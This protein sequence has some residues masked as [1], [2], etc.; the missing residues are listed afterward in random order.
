ML[1]LFGII[2]INYVK[3]KSDLISVS[4]ISFLKQNLIFPIKWR[5]KIHASNPTVAFV[6]ITT[7]YR[8]SITVHQGHTYIPVYTSLSTFCGLPFSLIQG[9]NVSVVILLRSLESRLHTPTPSADPAA[10]AAPNAV[11]SGMEGRT[12]VIE[13][14]WI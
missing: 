4:I 9:L 1:K 2:S 6:S 3:K 11:V 10:M 12:T 13:Q 8:Y 14:D 7:I 5:K